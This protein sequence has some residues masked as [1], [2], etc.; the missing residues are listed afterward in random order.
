MVVVPGLHHRD[1]DVRLVVQDV[2]GELALAPS[3]H[4][5]ADDDL[6]VG[7]VDLLTHL[8]IDVPPGRGQRRGDE[9]GTDVPFRQVFL[10]HGVPASQT[11]SY[12]K[13]RFLAREH[14]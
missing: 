3:D 8:G 6:T 4:A 2:V 12:R 10:V 9:L 7:Q 1:G 14:G 11:L 13:S 5:S